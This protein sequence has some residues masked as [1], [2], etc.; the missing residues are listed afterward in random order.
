M[1]S[2]TV[3]GL[4]SFNFGGL[5]ILRSLLLP[6]VI[7]LTI[8]DASAPSIAEGGSRYKF[9]YNLGITALVTGVCML[10]LPSL[11]EVLFKT[12]QL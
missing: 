1:V 8:S 11:A 7:V 6:L 3:A 5:D 12:V 4:T 2:T 9:C 10:S